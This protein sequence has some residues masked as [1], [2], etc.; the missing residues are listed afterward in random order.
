VI[1]GLVGCQA[2]VAVWQ[3]LSIARGDRK[4]ATLSAQLL[5]CQLDQAR[6]RRSASGLSWSGWRAFRLAACEDANANGDIRTFHLE[7]HDGQAL[8]PYLPGQFLTVQLRLPDR[9]VPVVRCYT[10]SEAARPD[11]YQISVKRVPG[12]IASGQLFD[13]SAGA[14][15]DARPP[16][17]SFTLER[18]LD[19][20]LI[21]LAGGVGITPMLAVLEHLSAHQPRREVRLYYGVGGPSDVVDAQALARWSKRSSCRVQVC[22]SRPDEAALAVIERDPLYQRGRI[23]L[24]QLSD[25]LGA[26]IG[27]HAFFICGPAE[28]TSTMLAG[29]SKRG[30]APSRLISEAFGAPTA[31]STR[32]L[33]VKTNPP[34]TEPIAVSVRFERSGR[35]LRFE[36]KRHLSLLEL[37]ESAGIE[38]NCGCRVG[39]CMTCGVAVRSGRVRYPLEPSTPPA[40]GTC[41]VCIAVPETDLV[42]DA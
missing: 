34:A 42:L 29:L 21:L 22:C 37:A 23:D 28:M 9:S 38:I 20:P 7:P 35:E 27:H 4:R 10:L 19:Q 5:E 30:V 17:G 31:N 33:Q 2:L 1:L 18:A 14:L 26:S 3:A 6:T 16:A 36:P 24:A 32:S 12:G 11:R 25:E 13:L 8:P 15:I 39:N 41:L 40:K